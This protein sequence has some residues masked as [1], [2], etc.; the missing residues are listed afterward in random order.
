MHQGVAA[1]FMAVTVVAIVPAWADD[2]PHE[3]IEQ[4]ETQAREMYY[5]EKLDADTIARSDC[6]VTRKKFTDCVV[7]NER[8]G[9]TYDCAKDFPVMPGFFEA[10]TRHRESRKREEA[11][12]REERRRAALPAPRV[13]M[14]AR[15]VIEGS[16][17]GRPEVVNRTQIAGSVR[18]QW[19]YGDGFYLYL[20]NGRVTA[21]QT[22]E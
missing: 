3:R 15:Q 11:R 12:A 2:L 6:I 5:C 4:I 1:L 16:N 7:Y 19:V 13:G 21:I 20:Q 18:E 17:W 22:R 9:N 10:Q 8:L 14:T